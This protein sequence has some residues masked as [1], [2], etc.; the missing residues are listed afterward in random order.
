LDSGRIIAQKQPFYTSQKKCEHNLIREELLLDLRKAFDTVN[1]NVLIS[2]LSKFN[3]SA[4]TLAWLSTYLS[5]R[6]QCVRIKNV[7]SSYMKNTMRL[8]QGSVLGPLLFS[9]YINDLPQHSNG[10]DIQ[11]Y[12]DDTVL[13]THAKKMLS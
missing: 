3:L 12:A 2:K 9:L 10:V 8:P 7:G 13:H 6:M 4:K 11:L 5:N 1:H